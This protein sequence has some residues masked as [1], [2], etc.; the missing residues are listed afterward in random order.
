M[1]RSSLLLMLA[2]REPVHGILGLIGYA[3]MVVGLVCLTLA[4]TGSG[5]PMVVSG[6]VGLGVWYGTIR[7][8]WTYDTAVLRRTPP[9]EQLYLI[10]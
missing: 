1:R 5:L 9:G 3:A 2:L 7:L 6:L 10:R 4:L 8:R